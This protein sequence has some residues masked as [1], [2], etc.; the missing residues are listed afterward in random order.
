[1]TWLIR[2]TVAT[3]VTLA[4]WF[5]IWVAATWMIADAAVRCDATVRAPANLQTALNG[6]GKGATVCLDGVFRTTTAIRPLTG[7]TIVGGT[8]EYA[9]SYNV[10]KGCTLT[11]G[12]YLR[13]GNVTLRRVEVR[14]FEGRGVVCGPRTRIIGSYLHDNHQNAIACT[15]NHGAW[16]IRI[17]GNRIVGNGDPKLEGESAAGVKIMELSVP[18]ATVT[19]GAVIRDNVV[20]GNHGNGLWLDRTSSG[21]LIVGN[22]VTGNTRHGFRCEKCGG[23]V[24]VRDNTF[25]SN[26]FEGIDF[27]ST[28]VGS[29]IDNTAR[30]NGTRNTRDPDIRVWE[31]WRA[32]KT[33][34]AIGDD[35]L[36]YHIRSIVVRGT[37][38]SG[39]VIGC[40][41]SGVTCSA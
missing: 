28:A 39:S 12:Y 20:S 34:P 6:A 7:Q 11:N 13:S 21:A 2:L 41:L 10:C 4:L 35:T 23:P 22:D 33:Y 1:M 36:G 38:M 18:G 17:I 37:S 3:V 5:L 31:D 29:I 16:N 8:L 19:S 27:T 14:G 32:Q 9:G 30:S 26:G 25:T 15:A 40:N 24:E